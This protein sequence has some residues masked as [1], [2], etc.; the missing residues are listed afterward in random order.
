MSKA[1]GSHR[2]WKKKTALRRKCDRCDLRFYSHFCLLLHLKVH[3][4]N[5]WF[6]CSI[7]KKPFEALARFL[8]HGKRHIASK[9]VFETL[10]LYDGMTFYPISRKAPII[11]SPIQQL[12]CRCPALNQSVMIAS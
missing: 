10:L 8:K 9:F 3:L 4:R 12:S 6:P 2:S 7:C 1:M 11:R 5:G